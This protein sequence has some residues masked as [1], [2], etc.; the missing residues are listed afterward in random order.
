VI[1][2]GETCDPPSGTTCDPTC[3]LVQP[4][5]GDGVVEPGEGCDLGPTSWLCHNC[6]GTGC[7]SCYEA[8]V[9]P[10]DLCAGLDL[11]D[12]QACNALVTC[13]MNM[14]ACAYGGC[15]CKD[16]YSSPACGG[17]ADGQC[18]TQYNAVAH[19]NDPAVVL[20]QINDPT[21]TA[22]KIAATAYKFTTSPCGSICY[23]N[24]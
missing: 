7:D 17:V 11:K 9:Q 10:G 23:L 8:W 15:Y 12:T 13:M 2:P 20:A 24:H 18:V 1:D 21:T 6:R 5:C 14:A 22:G 19:S 4:V 3:Q 16:P